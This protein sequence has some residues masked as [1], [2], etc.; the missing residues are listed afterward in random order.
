MINSI[1]ERFMGN[2]NSRSQ[3]IKEYILPTCFDNNIDKN[4]FA[5]T[6]DSLN[7]FLSV[8]F[9]KS[10]FVENNK[11]DDLS[12]DAD[13]FYSI[14]NNRLNRMDF[15]K[16]NHI[17]IQL[18]AAVLAMIPQ[19]IVQALY[20]SDQVC[21]Q[22]FDKPIES[23]QIKI[24]RIA[25]FCTKELKLQNITPKN[26]AEMG[27]LIYAALLASFYETNQNVRTATNA[28]AMLPRDALLSIQ[29]KYKLN[30][31]NIYTP[32]SD[33]KLI[34]TA[35]SEFGHKKF[36]LNN[37]LSLTPNAND[38]YLK[39]VSE[40]FSCMLP[41]GDLCKDAA[42]GKLFQSLYSDIRSL[43]DASDLL[44]VS[45]RSR[46]D[47][48]LFLESLYLFV[49][50]TMD[51]E[52]ARFAPVYIDANYFLFNKHHH[53]IDD[54]AEIKKEISAVAKRIVEWH[55]QCSELD[56]LIIMQLDEQHSFFTRHRIEREMLTI[57]DQEVGP[58][59]RVIGN[60]MGLSITNH[61]YKN[62]ALVSYN[63]FARHIYLNSV[64]VSNYKNCS[65]FVTAYSKLVP[66][67]AEAILYNLKFSKIKAIDFGIMDLFAEILGEK[68][69][70]I[71]N[72]FELYETYCQSKLLLDRK[73]ISNIAT[74]T[75]HTIYSTAHRTESEPLACYFSCIHQSFSSFFISWHF[76]LRLLSFDKQADATLFE[77]VLPK[78]ITDF[79]VPH[80]NSDR[81]NESRILE[82]IKNNYDSMSI[83]GK[84]EMIFLLGRMS[85]SKII[86]EA[87]QILLKHYYASRANIES[88]SR[89]P[90]YDENSRKADLLHLRGIAISLIYYGND[91]ISEEYILDL[92][93]DKLANM[94]NRGFHLE[95]YGD[96]PVKDKK[97]IDMEDDV[98]RGK[99]TMISL[100]R[101]IENRFA[102]R[103]SAPVLENELFT[104][105]SLIQARICTGTSTTIFPIEPYIS[106]CLCF[107]EKYE[108]WS[109]HITN[110]KIIT[111]FMMVKKNF[112]DFL[113][114]A[115]KSSVRCELYNTY[116]DTILIPRTGWV[117]MRIPSPESIS[118]HMYNAWLTAMIFL[119]DHLE[120]YSEYNKSKI[121]TM[122]QIH[123]L[124]EVIT[125]D[126]RKP[127]KDGHPEYDR[128]ED[129]VMKTLFLHDTYSDDVSFRTY[130]DAWH[131][132]N[133]RKT[134]NAIIAR[135]I[136]TIQAIYQFCRYYFL[137]SELLGTA[138]KT[139]W[140][141]EASCIRSEIGKAIF[142]EIVTHNAMF[143]DFVQDK[144]S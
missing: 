17:A 55:N 141:S 75:F 24:K 123:D 34:F 78:S 85:N 39:K 14:I 32:P 15:S 21:E 119:P 9:S 53:L 92:L 112:S 50:N 60:S 54:I 72:V 114:G 89:N 94:I 121:L 130:Y 65:N 87:K 131:E 71:N 104:L 140:L 26:S 31:E 132:W 42:H 19:A 43:T 1:I 67:K 10:M 47:I 18:T 88:R 49:V 3:F 56:L 52:Q 16:K 144:Q 62:S 81:E 115:K 97:L 116:T 133:E 13:K 139:H 118:N 95:Y 77:T 113:S 33:T 127:D 96:K 107:L 99:R 4:L 5:G 37:R 102:Q 28:F 66:Y 129:E 110:E 136:D 36:N 7:Q 58:Y 30:A 64:D 135:D 120:D 20:A 122:L 59:C 137:H 86:S 91:V 74:T 45:S 143:R 2:S 73:R 57:F 61:A 93:N 105:C 106:K 51:S 82:L 125:G 98:S 69:H 68:M 6:N 101:N 80:M 29:P 108:T 44:Y 8:C 100:C 90:D 79:I 11:T 83:W 109:K 25:E 117:D 76:F 138:K 103:T 12:S 27:V 46:M 124:G 84:D 70:L 41:E 128:N 23:R 111:Y 35:F 63:H 48:K 134:I 22:I 126:I 40:L 38:A 142:D